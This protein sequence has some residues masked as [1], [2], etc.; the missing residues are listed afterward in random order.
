MPPPRKKLIEQKTLAIRDAAFPDLNP[1]DL[2]HHRKSDG[3]TSIPRTLPIVM[4]IIDDLTKGSP[5]SKTYFALWARVF[6]EMYVNLQNAEELAYYSGL[7]GQRWLRD[8]KKRMESLAELG[9]IKLANGP[10]G[11]MMHAVIINPHFAVWR[12]YKA[13][14]PGLTKAAFDSLLDR[15]GQIGMTDMAVPLPEE[16]V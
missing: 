16:T 1:D 10:R 6:P 9:F 12:L 3:F 13:G 11:Q 15:A 14:T 2:W 4:N 5:A 8:W 7:A